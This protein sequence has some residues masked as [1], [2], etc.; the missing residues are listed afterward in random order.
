MTHL[1]SVN[2]VSKTYKTSIGMVNVLDRINFFLKEGEFVIIFG[3]S[4]V[5]KS[6]FLNI[7]GTFEKP[8]SGKI[9]YKN[10]DMYSLSDSQI[11]SIRNKEIGF[12]FQSFNL[13]N[14]MTVKENI[15]LPA[16]LYNI[17]EEERTQRVKALLFNLGLEKKIDNKPFELSGGEQQ[18]VAIA[19]ALINK[20]SMVLADE[21]TG[22]L[23]TEISMDVC[24]ILRETTKENSTS[25]IMVTHNKE[26]LSF[27]DRII[28]MNN[29][30]KNINEYEN[31][32]DKKIKK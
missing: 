3:P 30:H 22:N 20:P 8:S 15:E 10:I 11:S 23:D 1:L 32:S 17:K 24:N 12:V 2:D 13:I 7:I 19:R 4:G 25:V 16:I 6:T 31:Y 29:S 18:R 27:A 26:L 9:L 28:Y 21:P 14:R 5:G